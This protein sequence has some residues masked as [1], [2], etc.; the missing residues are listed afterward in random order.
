MTL[1]R[2]LWCRR[3]GTNEPHHSASDSFF[4]AA[5]CVR[6][7]CCGER[8]Q[9]PLKVKV[10]L[11]NSRWVTT[12]FH[13]IEVPVESSWTALM[14]VMNLVVDLCRPNTFIELGTT[15]GCSFFA[16]LFAARAGGVPMN[17]TAIGGWKGDVRS[18]TAL[19]RDVQKKAAAFGMPVKLI[20]KSL[21][22]AACDF[23]DS[24][25]DLLHVYGTQT[26]A[27]LMSNFQA[28]LP[29]LS[30]RAVVL[31]SNIA[32]RGSNCGAW[33]AWK[34][35]STAYPS[36]DFPHANGLGI[37]FVGHEV[38]PAMAG[39]LGCWTEEQGFAEFFR[40]T[41]RIAGHAYGTDSGVWADEPNSTL[42]QNTR[43]ARGADV[44]QRDGAVV[45]REQAEMLA[46]HPPAA[47]Q[48]P[49][50]HQQRMVNI[51]MQL[52]ELQ[53][54][55]R[56][57]RA[58]GMWPLIRIATPLRKRFKRVTQLTDKIRQMAEAD[59]RLEGLLTESVT[60]NATASV[61]R[62]SLIAALPKIAQSFR[63]HGMRPGHWVA[64][65]VTKSFQK[66]GFT[67]I[68]NTFYA[69]TPDMNEASDHEWRPQKYAAAWETVRKTPAEEILAELVQFMGELTGVPAQLPDKDGQFYWLNQMFSPIDAVIYYGLIRSLQPRRIIEVGSGYST[70]IALMAAGRTSPQIEISCIEPYPSP[71]LLQQKRKLK[72]LIQRKVQDVDP[73]LFETLDPGDILFI[74]SSHCSRLGSDLNFLMFEAI[75]RLKVGVYLH[76]HDIF[77]PNEY[78]RVWL[79]DVGIM[80]NEQ[81][82]LLAFLMFNEN[83]ELLWSS[84]IAA[85]TIEK[86]LTSALHQVLPE[87]NDFLDKLGPY[88]GGSVWLRKIK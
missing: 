72:M 19:M 73:L 55:N 54:T 66:H 25:I 53:E 4:G 21:D 48:L 36:L 68:A 15:E 65:E 84:S 10:M 51:R 67:I 34:Q 63:D 18:G 20:R 86:Q 40:M 31:F 45:Q 11:L 77:L 8:R 27:S 76:F 33:L 61:S 85:T 70:A 82:L 64:P 78:P 17:S 41:A 29:K 12:L 42:L 13:P 71:F 58:S 22:E 28:W 69:V 46:A 52:G 7:V 6:L 35:L 16:A 87:G 60:E 83:F 32:V 26:H 3:V 56:A 43:L 38:A 50:V 62:T 75:P 37:L 79:E 59:G 74:D 1:L 81:Y 80:W 44:A 14:P 47:D 57:I 49:N 5:N 39:L 30:P 24:H 88:S 2:E 9:A 23:D